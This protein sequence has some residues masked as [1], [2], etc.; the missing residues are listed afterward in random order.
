MRTLLLLRHGKSSWDNPDLCDFER[1]LNQR[2]K[3]SV[4]LVGGFINQQVLKPDIILCSA[5]RRTRQTLK[6][7]RNHVDFNCEIQFL[8]ELYL[9]SEK[10][11]LQILRELPQ[12]YKTVLVIGHNPTMHTLSMNFT[13]NADPSDMSLLT[14]K[15]PTCGLAV[16]EFHIQSWVDICFQSAL[17][18]H[19]TTPK[20]LTNTDQVV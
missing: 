10:N 9:I 16:L 6:L 19:F 8:D 4:P 15:F 2:G 11:L 3:A 1:P 17:L 14:Q 5:A 13:A 12:L 20:M 18:K 7:L